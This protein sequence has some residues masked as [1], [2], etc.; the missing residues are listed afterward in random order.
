MR[1]SILGVKEEA[2]FNSHFDSPREMTGVHSVLWCLEGRTGMSFDA[3]RESGSLWFPPVEESSTELPHTRHGVG[4]H[5]LCLQDL[6]P[7][8]IW[9]TI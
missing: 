3:V 1:G 6:A 8:F 9:R 4:G 5:S 2:S 7:L